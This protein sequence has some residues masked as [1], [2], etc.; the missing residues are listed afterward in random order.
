MGPLV[1]RAQHERVRSYIDIGREER[2][3]PETLQDL[4]TRSELVDGFF[5]APTLFLRGRSEMRVAQE[6]IF[7][8]VQ[9]LIPF[10]DEAD[11]VRIANDSRYGLAGVVYTRDGAR[12]MRM[13]KALQIGNLAINDPIKAS[14]DAPFGGFKESGLGK[15]RGM[16]AILE[17][18]QVKNVRFSMR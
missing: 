1:S 2:A 13:C 8:P 9:V 15:E 11:A 5:A 16:D 3:Q 14:A 17:N 12:A 18:T 4:S 6:E 7:G 10:R